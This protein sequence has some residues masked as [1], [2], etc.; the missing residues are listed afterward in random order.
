MILHQQISSP[1]LELCRH[2]ILVNRTMLDGYCHL[3][4]TILF[5]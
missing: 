4:I 3:Y 5:C 2:N 1:E